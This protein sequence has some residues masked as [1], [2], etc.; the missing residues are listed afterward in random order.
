MHIVAP[1]YVRYVRDSNLR[2]TWK[3][4][5]QLLREAAEWVIIGYSFPPEDLAIRSLF[6]RAYHARCTHTQPS[7]FRV[8][9]VQK[10]TGAKPR[11]EAYF[12]TEENNQQFRYEAGGLEA[13][14]DKNE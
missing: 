3:H 1:S 7:V 11:Y 13:F 6:C 12:A 9:V 14:L 2:E 4:A 5:L 10:G 8:H